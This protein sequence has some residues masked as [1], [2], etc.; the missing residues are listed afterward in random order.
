MKYSEEEIA[1]VMKASRILASGYRNAVRN[2]HVDY[3]DLVQTAVVCCLE[4]LAAG[5][6]DPSKGDLSAYL[7]KCARND[8]ATLYLQSAR[9]DRVPRHK[10]YSA[11]QAG[12]KHTIDI[13]DAAQARNDHLQMEAAAELSQLRRHLAKEL[14][15][16][17]VKDR[18]RLLDMEDTIYWK[19]K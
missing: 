1:A 2:T 8:V 17:S 3:E 15:K 19:F 5:K 10:L 6:Y 18:E 14:A 16:P 11:I 7:W 4:I 12:R 9:P 13:A